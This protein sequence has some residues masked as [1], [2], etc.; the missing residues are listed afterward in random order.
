MAFL[1][2]FFCSL[3]RV[4]HFAV[5]KALRDVIIHHTCGLHVSIDHRGPYKFKAPLLEILT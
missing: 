3:L 2:P 4:F 5:P 1:E